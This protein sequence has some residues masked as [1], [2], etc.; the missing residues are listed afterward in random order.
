M[1]ERKRPKYFAE[2][3]GDILQLWQE[4]PITDAE[5]AHKRSSAASGQPCIWIEGV[6]VH[7][8]IFSD[9]TAW[10]ALNGWRDGNHWLR[11]E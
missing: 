4:R 8:L 5:L 6:R 11:F 10:D 2:R 7:V 9:G 3:E 1:A